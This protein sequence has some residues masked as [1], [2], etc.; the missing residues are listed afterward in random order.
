MLRRMLVTAVLAATVAGASGSAT[1]HAAELQP[2]GPQQPEMAWSIS[3]DSGSRDAAG[4]GPI[5][6]LSATDTPPWGACGVSTNP[7][8][9]V[10]LFVKNRVTDYV[11]RC[12]GPKYSS[13]PRWGYR[14]ILW[15]H[16][17]DFER[18]AVGTYQNWRDV[19]D[20]A[21]RSNTSDP[22]VT[23]H[24]ARTGKTCFSRLIYLVNTR[25]N[26]VVRT[27]VVRMVVSSK[28]NIITSYP[29]AHCT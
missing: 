7:G 2:P 18:L 3:P 8:K 23:R 24:R 25:T 19:A 10:R 29:G 15:R 26:Q 12:G 20:L 6:S 14:H 11:L 9:L 17:D 5:R 22:D 21:M 27:A 4:T 13:S 1:A 28:N 16:R